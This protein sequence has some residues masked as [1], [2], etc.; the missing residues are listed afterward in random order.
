MAL[1]GP[2]PKPPLQVVREGNPGKRK[3]REGVKVPLVS[4][5]SP[6]PWDDLFPAVKTPRRRDGMTDDEWRLWKAGV[7][8][9]KR[10]RARAEAEWNRVVPVLTHSAGLADVDRAVVVDYCVTV[11]RLFECERQLSL[12]GLVVMGQRGEC[13]NPLTTVAAQYRTQ[14]KAYIG[15]LGLSPA[16]RGRIEAPRDDDDD[17]DVFD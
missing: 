13:R 1:P 2:R 16:S 14:M 5:T 3:V 11:A 10:S 7:E 6:P 4:D 9:A 12:Q 8:A 15:E 17:S